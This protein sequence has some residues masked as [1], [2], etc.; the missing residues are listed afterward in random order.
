MDKELLKVLGA[1]EQRWNIRKKLVEKRHSCIITITLCI[2]LIFRTDEEYWT[3][4]LQL[5]RRFFKVLIS[6]GQQVRFEGCM[7]NDDGPAFFISTK[8]NAKEMKRICVEAE[9]LIPGGRILDIDIM[10]SDGIPISRSDINLP[11]RKCFVCENPAM[12]CVSRKLHSEEEIYFCVKQL[13]EQIVMQLS[14]VNHCSYIS[15]KLLLL[16]SCQTPCQNNSLFS[17]KFD[18]R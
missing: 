14:T 18:G 1:R 16:T 4:F 2:P 9:E 10:N 12:A 5:C 3:L 17:I 7:R 8:T 6:I 13:K 11:P 15:D